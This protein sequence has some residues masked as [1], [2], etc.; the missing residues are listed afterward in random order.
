MPEAMDLPSG[1]L[2]LCVIGGGRDGMPLASAFLRAKLPAGRGGVLVTG[3]LMEGED[4]TLLHSLASGRSDMRLIEFVTDPQ[5]LMCCA[6]RVISMG[7]YNTVC[8]VLAFQKRALIVPRVTPRR[9]QII[10]AERF[11]ALGLLD[12]LHPDGLSPGAL[13]SWIGAEAGAVRAAETVLDFHGARRLPEL[14]VEALLD[15]ARVA[16]AV[17]VV[18]RNGKAA[19]HV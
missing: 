17:Q 10:R 18:A 14:L 19:G 5:P 16:P 12:V 15:A 13:E 6:D 8:E 11:S 9:E 3:P 7:G 4:R 1:D 2:T